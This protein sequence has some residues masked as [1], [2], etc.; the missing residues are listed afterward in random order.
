MSVRRFMCLVGM[1]CVVGPASAGSPENPEI[2]DSEGDI[3]IHTDFGAINVAQSEIDLL[4]VW[5]ESPAQIGGNFTVSFRVK[6]LQHVT[7]P[8]ETALYS[9]TMKS[10]DESD[11]TILLENADGEWSGFL[12]KSW[13]SGQGESYDLSPSPDALN[14]TIAVSLPAD[15]VIRGARQLKGSSL[16]VNSETEPLQ[17]NVW[18]RDWAPDTGYGRDF[19]APILAAPISSTPAPSDASVE[20]PF[21]SVTGFGP[22]LWLASV[23][24]ILAA[25]PRRR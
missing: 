1:I 22:E 19:D 14:D 15:S 3:E 2:V 17:H 11:I 5:I 4:A 18:F 6:D 21:R 13:S 8:R 10:T 16:L 24:G 7:L 20:G 12:L 25:K 9:L 23:L